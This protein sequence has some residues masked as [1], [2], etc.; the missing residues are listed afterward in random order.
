MAAACWTLP[1]PQ[2][3]H[4]CRPPTHA[5][6][7]AWV[8]TLDGVT[9]RHRHNLRAK[10]PAPVWP[11]VNAGATTP[12]GCPVLAALKRQRTLDEVAAVLPGWER[13]AVSKRLL[14]LLDEDAAL[15]RYEGGVAVWEVASC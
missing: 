9:L 8:V 12:P 6:V 7:Y 10:A 13:A 5:E 15:V 4:P 14:A 3:R 1:V 2:R 11:K